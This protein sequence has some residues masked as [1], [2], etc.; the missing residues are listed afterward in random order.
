MAPLLTCV[1]ACRFT[2]TNAATDG[3]LLVVV[4][5]IRVYLEYDAHLRSG[6]AAD[7][8]TPAGYREFALAFNTM[9]SLSSATPQFSEE[10][11]HGPKITGPSP[12]FTDLVRDNVPADTQHNPAPQLPEGGRWINPQ[13]IELLEEALWQNLETTKRKCEW[14]ERAITEQKN[15]RTHTSFR[16]R[17][18]ADEYPINRGEESSSSGHNTPSTLGTS[19]QTLAPPTHMEVDDEDGE[20][21]TQGPAPKTG[22]KE[23]ARI[24][25]AK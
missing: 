3:D 2:L 9:Q 8:A 5:I 10:K 21:T 24:P 14:R 19:I 22:R 15:K 17:N 1:G 13:R 4:D 7:R 11:T 23:G 12:S 25:K 16:S 6:T 18:I 20:T